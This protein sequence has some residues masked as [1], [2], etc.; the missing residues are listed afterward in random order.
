[1]QQRSPLGSLTNMF[2]LLDNEILISKPDKPSSSSFAVTC[3]SIRSLS[4]NPALPVF[5]TGVLLT[6]VSNLRST[7]K[8]KL[9]SETGLPVLIDILSPPSGVLPVL[10]T[11]NLTLKSVMCG[12][13][14]NF[15][16]SITYNL[17]WEI[18]KNKCF[19]CEAHCL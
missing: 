3:G 2:P 1:M 8:P 16:Q 15:N 7:S 4:V 6:G 14:S 5:T 19:N 12:H 9:I 17:C 11:A 10:N 13:L 18:F